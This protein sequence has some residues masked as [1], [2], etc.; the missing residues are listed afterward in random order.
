MEEKS[1]ATLSLSLPTSELNSPTPPSVIVS[2]P[3][4]TISVA[5]P[6]GAKKCQ[7]L[8]NILPNIRILGY[9]Y[10]VPDVEVVTTYRRW[11]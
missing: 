2:I 8:H 1:Q 10:L 7:F 5:D 11:L 4:P 3:L 9:G 6:A